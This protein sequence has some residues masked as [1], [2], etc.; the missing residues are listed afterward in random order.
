MYS[1]IMLTLDGSDLSRQAIPHA[2]GV[3]KATGAEV[4]LAQVIDSEAQ[5]LSQASG[6]T[7]EPMPAGRVNAEIAAEAVQAQREAAQEH[8][9]GAKA[10]IEG[11]GVSTV[12]TVVLE[13]EP[14]YAIVEAVAELGVDLVVM[15]TRGRSGFKR[16]VLGSIAD[17]V[18]R[19]TPSAAVLLVRPA[20]E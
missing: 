14:G 9:D 11:Q 2:V 6:V 19:N 20:E 7:I 4:L 8:L 10:E 17:H 1:K 5:M 16:A 18:V 3:A 13:G 12:S 15:A